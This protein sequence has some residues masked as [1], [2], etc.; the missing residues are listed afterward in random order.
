MPKALLTRLHTVGLLS[1]L[2]LGWRGGLLQQVNDQFLTC[3]LCFPEQ[4]PLIKR[5]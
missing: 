2:A 3:S 1:Y 5:S 4:K